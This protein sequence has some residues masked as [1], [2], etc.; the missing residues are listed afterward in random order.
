MRRCDKTTAAPQVAEAS[1]PSELPEAAPVA[2]RDLAG[3]PL[4]VLVQ[5][6]DGTARALAIRDLYAGWFNASRSG[7]IPF[8][9]NGWAPLTE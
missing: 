6:T 8:S 7:A 5:V 1:A 2:W 9:P 4:G 3:A